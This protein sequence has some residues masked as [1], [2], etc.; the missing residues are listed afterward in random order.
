MQ[1]WGRRVAE[2]GVGAAP[3]PRAA[4]TAERLAD[5]IVAATTPEARA[6]AAALGARLRAEGGAARAAE[7]LEALA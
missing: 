4:L 5:A 1:L 3:I 6:R 2:L 7:L